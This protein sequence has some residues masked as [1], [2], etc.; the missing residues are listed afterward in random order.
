MNATISSLLED[1]RNLEE[2]QCT[3]NEI[4]TKLEAELSVLQG[5][6]TNTSF[7]SNTSSASVSSATAVARKS[8]DRSAPRVSL[9]LRHG[10]LILFKLNLQKSGGFESEVRKSRRLSAY[11]EHRRQSYW[12]DVRDCGT[13]TDPVGEY[14]SMSFN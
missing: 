11:D 1:K 14:T 2:K 7:E 13:M 3:L 4:V 6:K 8:L 9:D 5:L 10:T 12:N